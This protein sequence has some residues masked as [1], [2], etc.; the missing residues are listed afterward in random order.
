[1][2][3]VRNIRSKPLIAR[4]SAAD[5]VRFAATADDPQQLSAQVVNYILARCDHVLW[6]VDANDVRALVDA[7]KPFAAIA[8]YFANVGQR[9]D[10]ERLEVEGFSFGR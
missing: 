5:G 1:M 10:V 9:W 4:V 7:G 3:T 2:T 6:P 8:T